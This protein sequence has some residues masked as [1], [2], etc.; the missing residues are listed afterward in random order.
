MWQ[1]Y[2]FNFNSPANQ[3]MVVTDQIIVE[4]V[5]LKVVVIIHVYLLNVLNPNFVHITGVTL[6]VTPHTL[7][8]FSNYCIKETR[9]NI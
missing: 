1:G 3:M 6:F 8:L 2:H 4:V 5:F 9:Y 7:F